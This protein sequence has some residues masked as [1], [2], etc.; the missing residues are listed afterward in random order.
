ML[1]KVIIEI[2]VSYTFRCFHGFRKLFNG[3]VNSA[4]RLG[5]TIRI[6]D[7]KMIGVDE[8]IHTKGDDKNSIVLIAGFNGKLEGKIISE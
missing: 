7:S 3:I 1:K 5:C 4:E 6:F 8:Y 2:Y